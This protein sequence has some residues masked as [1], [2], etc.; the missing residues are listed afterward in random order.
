MGR[1]DLL[2]QSAHHICDFFDI[3]TI[4]FYSTIHTVLWFVIEILMDQQRWNIASFVASR[5]NNFSLT[6][7]SICWSMQV[8]VNEAFHL[9][10]GDM[11]I[12]QV[13]FQIAYGYY[14]NFPEWFSGICCDCIYRISIRHYNAL[15]VPHQC[16]HR[17]IYC[18]GKRISYVILPL[19][20]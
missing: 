11:W 20:K 15:V 17:M 14:Q 18:Q 9:S 2:T 6:N 12:T 7:P 5:Y 16:D 13:S 3:F 1:V 10:V 4:L 19:F 8:G